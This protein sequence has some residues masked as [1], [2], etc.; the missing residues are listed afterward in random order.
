[1]KTFAID[2][3]TYYD[4][5]CSVTKL[6]AEAYTRHPRY[7]CGMV[8]VVGPGVRFVGE[9]QDVPWSKIQGAVWVAHNAQFDRWVINRMREA[10]EI[11]AD[12]APSKWVDTTAIPAYLQVGRSLDVA[13]KVLLRKAPDKTVR[14]KMKGKHFKDLDKTDWEVLCQYAL[15]DSDLCLELYK[16]YHKQIPDDEWELAALTIDQGDHG[17]QIDRRLLETFIGEVQCR[18]KLALDE[19]P[20]RGEKP[21][22][23]I[24][25][26]RTQLASDGILGMPKSTNANDPDW[27]TFTERVDKP[28]LKAFIDLRRISKHL[29]TLQTIENRIDADGV[30]RFSMK[31]CGSRLTGRWAGD[32]GLNLQNLTKGELFGASVRD[33]FIPRDGH[34][35]VVADLSNIEPR[36]AAATAEDDEFLEL[37]RKGMDIYEA[38]A[39]KALGYTDPRPLKQVDNDLRQRSKIA[40]LGL[41]YGM[42]H[43]RFREYA[44]MF[45]M[46]LSEEESEKIVKDY[47]KSNPD[48][49]NAWY[50]LDELFRKSVNDE[51]EITLPTG[52]VITYYNVDKK[53]VNGKT[54]YVCETERGKNHREFFWGS[55]IWENVV[56][57]TARDVFASAMLRIHKRGIRVAWSVHDEIICEV[58][59]DRA[60]ELMA[61][62]IEEMKRPHPALP[63]MPLDVEAHIADRYDK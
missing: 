18:Q 24:A 11:P 28:Y 59:E 20:W 8:S 22:T 19:I 56:Q 27:I 48:I 13:A 49:V 40:V 62:I 14:A 5:E 63:G 42:S 23:S 6:G 10:G 52:R 17:V 32:S 58:P 36:V 57:A 26:L 47:R 34:K 61:T 3:E 7:Y 37:V 54:G 1:M 39:R 51:F 55:K 60:E 2:T 41:G 43:V 53:S 29:A 44:K 46:D 31:Y 21:A 15:A 12:A 38:Y 35:F 25:A 4:E 30:L 33:L 45:G 16:K 9:P 50:Q